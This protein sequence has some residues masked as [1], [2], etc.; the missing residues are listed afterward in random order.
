MIDK[1]QI[2]R[3]NSRKSSGIVTTDKIVVNRTVAEAEWESP[4][5]CS[6]NNTVLVAEGIESPKKIADLTSGSIEIGNSSAMTKSGMTISLKAD[7]R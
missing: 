2:V 7:V 6:E 3:S 5:N 4:P 1:T